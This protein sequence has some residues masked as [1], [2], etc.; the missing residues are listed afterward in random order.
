MKE[1]ILV[2]MSALLGYIIFSAFFSS[3]TPTEA[4]QKIIEQPYANTQVSQEVAFNKA[5]KRHAEE[6]ILLDN[7]HKLEELKVYSEIKIHKK[8]SETKIELQKLENDFNHKIAI[9]KV[10]ANN[11]NKNKDNLT[12]I[13]LAL[14]IFLLVFILLK[15]KKQLNEIEL[16]KQD[17][18]DEMIAK[19]EYAE[20]IIAHIS[21]GN[22]SFD[23]EKR[24]LSILDELNGKTI[25]PREQENIYHPNPDIIQLPNNQ[26]LT[27]Y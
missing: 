18:Y 8:E 1:L 7:K 27:K 13:I 21:E 12:Y 11:E 5:D 9:L 19:K 15:Y 4:L 17:K 16:E 2:M 3:E 26:K 22:L 24:L 6:L 10:E 20:K 14:L 25:N 23:T